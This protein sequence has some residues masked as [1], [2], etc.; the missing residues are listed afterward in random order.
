MR[1]LGRHATL[2]EELGGRQNL[3]LA[4]AAPES[5]PDWLGTVVPWNPM[6]QTATAVRDLFGSPGGEPGHVWAAVTWPLALL[7]VF[8]PLAVY[9]GSRG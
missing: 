7:A 5:M 9:G 1:F 6:S 3:E 4:F 2:D 8:F